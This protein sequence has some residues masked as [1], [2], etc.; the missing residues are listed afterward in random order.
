MT[1][2]ALLGVSALRYWVVWV[3]GWDRPCELPL[4]L[5]L[6]GGGGRRESRGG[7]N[8]KTALNNKVV[9][10]EKTKGSVW[11]MFGWIYDQTYNVSGKS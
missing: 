5:T 4:S 11:K 10:V 7:H 9:T 8:G 3:E 1:V 2:A 6:E